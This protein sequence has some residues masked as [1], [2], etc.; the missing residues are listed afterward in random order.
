MRFKNFTLLLLLFFT[1]IY[2]SIGDP[3]NIYWSGAYFLVNYIV[4]FTMFSRER[5]RKVS[6]TGMALSISIFIYVVLKYFFNIEIQRIFTLILFV[7]SLISIIYI[8][9]K[10]RT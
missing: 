4:L 3:N 10:W 1:L 2:A 7:F 6:Y 9:K 8:E 5:D